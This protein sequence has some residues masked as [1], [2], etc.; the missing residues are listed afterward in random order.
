[1]GAVA[2]DQ[3]G[4]IAAGNSSGGRPFKH[5]G[6]VGDCPLIGC[7]IYA[8]NS[9]GGA[10]CTGVGEDII[11]VVMAKCAVDLL[12]GGETPQEAAPHAVSLLKG[13]VNGKGGVILV[14]RAGQVGF[15][16]NTAHMAYAYLTEGMGEP[17]VGV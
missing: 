6:R 5:P 3:R 14:N 11:R 7:G 4:S 13:R 12:E 10:A 15:A 17:V 2:L 16:F 8:D 1:V 9:I